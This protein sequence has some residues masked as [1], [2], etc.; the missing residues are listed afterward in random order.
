MDV[1][2]ILKCNT[3]ILN[4]KFTIFTVCPTKMLGVRDLGIIDLLVVGN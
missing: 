4:T 3:D 1:A 2:F